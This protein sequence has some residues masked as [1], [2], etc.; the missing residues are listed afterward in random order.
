MFASPLS[1]ITH[2]EIEDIIDLKPNQFKRVKAGNPPPVQAEEP[3][4]KLKIMRQD[5]EFSI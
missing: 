2:E 4:L 1:A 5:L 3:D